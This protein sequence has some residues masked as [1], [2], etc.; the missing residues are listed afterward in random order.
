MTFEWGCVLC[1]EARAAEEAPTTSSNNGA[2]NIESD[3]NAQVDADNQFLGDRRLLSKDA[4]VA[5]YPASAASES[6][7]DVLQ[8][9]LHMSQSSQ[10]SSSSNGSR[11]SSSP[12]CSVQL[13][14][15]PVK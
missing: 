14:R 11:M 5:G 7:T 8:G 6:S 12:T 3:S 9:L 1:R 13:A 15:S 10:A 4:R 2:D